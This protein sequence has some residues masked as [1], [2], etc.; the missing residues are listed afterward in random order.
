MGSETIYILDD[1]H[2]VRTSLGFFLANAGFAT[3]SFADAASFLD[4]AD[5]LSPGCVLLD[6]R[7]P[8]I[9]G[10]EVLERLATK[11]AAL[12]VVVM[13]GH[14]DVGTAVRAM[15]L[16]ALDFVE[17]P[18]EENM[19]LGILARVFML[20]D[21]QVR[22]LGRQAEMRARIARLTDREREVLVGLLAGRA[23]KLIAYDLGISVR[24]VEMHRSAMMERLGVR[25]LV[26]ALRIAIAAGLALPPAAAD[27]HV[28][29][30]S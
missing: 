10:F 21:N 16:G 26:E 2:S 22:D 29:V 7:M 8:E 18:Y 14:G 19:L 25:S 28:S 12:P 13:T 23:N 27:S 1:D 6:L 11:R 17:K 24:T 3:R 15:K 4:A 5:S 20:L 9:D 30:A